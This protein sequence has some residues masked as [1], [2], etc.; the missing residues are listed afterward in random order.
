METNEIRSTHVPGDVG[1]CVDDFES[2][3]LFASFGCTL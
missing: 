1:F 2:A 3:A